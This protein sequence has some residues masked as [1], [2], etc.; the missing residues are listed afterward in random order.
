M[1]KGSI[2][3]IE[4][5]GLVDGPGI[6][7][8]VFFNGCLLRCKYCHNPEMWSKEIGDVTPESLC[9]KILRNKPYFRR[10]HGGVTFSGGEPLLQGNF[11]IECCKILK[12]ENVHI[13]LDTCGVGNGNYEEILSYVDLVLFDIKH[14]TSEGYFF[15]TGHTIEDSL[16][17]ISVLNKLKKRV[18]IR[19]V[20]VPGIM[21]NDEYLD[22]LVDTLLGIH[23]IERIDFLPYHKM[24]EEKYVRLG[25]ESPFKDVSAM[26]KIECEKLYSR[27]MDKYASKGGKLVS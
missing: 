7:T 14:V 26:D 9:E 4:T 27:F 20:I 15:I 5:F 10:N 1:V 13:A 24:G 21:D 12:K 22:G 17:F 6:R 25:I 2:R 11:L 23:F 19:Q 8:V 16:E 3:S 18:W